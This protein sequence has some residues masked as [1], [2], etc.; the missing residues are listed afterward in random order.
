V[1][2]GPAQQFSSLGP[3]LIAESFTVQPDGTWMVTLPS[4]SGPEALNPRS[5]PSVGVPLGV[6]T[7]SQPGTAPGF[8]SKSS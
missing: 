4:A 2:V 7:F 1:P 5:S 8:S 3:P 6:K